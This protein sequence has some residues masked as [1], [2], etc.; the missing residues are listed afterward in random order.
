VAL[1]RSDCSN[2]PTIRG[3]RWPFLFNRPARTGLPHHF[4]RLDQAFEAN[5]AGNLYRLWNRMSSGSY[6]PPPVRAV[7]IP[8]GMSGSAWNFG[9][10]LRG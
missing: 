5:L 10:D 9:G 8:K 3:P 1:L 6:V 7:E 4:Y 2:S